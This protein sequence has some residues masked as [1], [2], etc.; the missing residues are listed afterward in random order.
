MDER[1]VG[2]NQWWSSVVL[3]EI[4]WFSMAGFV[5]TGIPDMVSGGQWGEGWR[6][7]EVAELIG[8]RL[9]RKSLPGISFLNGARRQ[10][11]LLQSER[12]LFLSSTEMGESWRE[13]QEVISIL[14]PFLWLR[15][16][17]LNLQQQRSSATSASCLR[18]PTPLKWVWALRNEAISLLQS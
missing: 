5:L 12:P 16:P 13:H 3:D 8:G 14:G 11:W 4:P 10:P 7:D 18:S 1:V 17:D 15:C 9:R 6:W 2:V